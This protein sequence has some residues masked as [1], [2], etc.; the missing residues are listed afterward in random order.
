MQR[1][2]TSE[3]IVLK[4]FNYGEAD[5]IVT[6]FSK[7]YG[8]ITCLAKAVRKTTSRKK[9]TIEVGTQAT[10]FWVR[11]KKWPLLTQAELISSHMSVRTNLVRATQLYQLLE[12]IDILTVEE[13]ENHEIY[14]LMVD[15][16]LLLDQDGYKK[17]LMIERFRLILKALGFTHDKHFSEPKLKAYIETLAERKLKAKTFLTPYIDQL[18]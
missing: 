6:I 15:S 11:S 2:F 9:S 13:Q 5:R 7:E 4:R 18:Q 17:E 10:F 12:I 1:S 3:G 16:L 14:T 8:K